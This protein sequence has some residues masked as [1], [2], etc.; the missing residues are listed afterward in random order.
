MLGRVQL[1]PWHGEGAILTHL[2]RAMC[3]NDPPNGVRIVRQDQNESSIG[4]LD[5]SILQGGERGTAHCRVR[6]SR[7][8]K[9]GYG[10]AEEAGKLKI[11]SEVWRKR[12]SK[13][14]GWMSPSF[15]GVADTFER[16]IESFG[17]GAAL[18]VYQHGECVLDLWGGEKDR[19][20]RPWERDTMAPSFSTTK[21][22]VSTLLH[23]MVDRGL[24]DYDDPVAKHWPEFAQAG[25]G[26]ITVRQVLSHQSGLY[27]IRQMIDDASCMLDWVY[28]VKAIEQAEPV[29]PPGERTGY[30]GLTYG[31][32]VGEILQRVT[33]KPFPE[34][35]QDELV[36]PL[37]LDGMYIG[38]PDDALDRAAELLWPERSSRLLGRLSR[39]RKQWIEDGF[40]QSMSRL[41]GGMRDYLKL[42]LD[43][44]S[45]MD[46]LAPRGISTFDFGSEDTLRAAIPAAN[47][48]FTAR[49]LA[50]M[51]SAL[52]TGG[53]I[54]GVRL[55][56]HQTLAR[57]TER[58]PRRGGLSVIPFDMRWRLGYHGIFTTLGVPSEA[59][60]HFGFGGSGG[61]ADP[62]R[63]LSVA[64]I[65]NRGM[66]TPFGDTRTARISG[67]VLRATGSVLGSLGRDDAHGVRG[68]KVPPVRSPVSGP[69]AQPGAA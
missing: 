39:E 9:C 59:F 45:I 51:Y 52:S 22:I 44:V 31:F 2:R 20:G 19:E 30:H 15:R 3:Q 24:L 61:W 55:L 42:D 63:E 40:H 43:L 32:L 18:C 1:E 56:S 69:E 68:A 10:I 48:L 25:K 36:G 29:H 28:M 53:E 4:R 12:Q 50:K 16:I 27:H 5:C 62:S 64:V 6:R 13:I 57:A 65:V 49:S 11:L 58:Q 17:G 46:A 23:I 41:R 38:A 37:G 7:R 14:D 54:D 47:G 66:G 67:A 35:V 33:N 60:G 8:A 34:L 21:G 26:A